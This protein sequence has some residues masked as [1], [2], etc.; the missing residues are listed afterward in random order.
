MDIAALGKTSVDR[1]FGFKLHLVVNDG[2]ELL[3]GMVALGN[4]DDHKPIMKNKLMRL[5]DKFSPWK[6]SI[7]ETNNHQF[8]NIPQIKHSRHRSPVNFCV[9]ILCALIAYSYQSKKRSIRF[10]WIPRSTNRTQVT[11]E[12]IKLPLSYL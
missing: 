10:D 9:N 12:K 2:R 5:Y 3:K 1:F 8:K 11:L 7:I 4:V 6:C